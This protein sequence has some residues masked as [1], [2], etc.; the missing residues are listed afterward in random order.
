[1]G[2][3]TYYEIKKSG[4]KNDQN[5]NKYNA[6][7]KVEE[8]KCVSTQSGTKVWGCDRKQY[9]SEERLANE[10]RKTIGL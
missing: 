10:R 4:N 2:L 5:K 1:M 3:H 6:Q 9:Q 7:Q 8:S